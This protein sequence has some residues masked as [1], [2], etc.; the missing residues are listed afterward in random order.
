M[1]DIVREEEK[2]LWES[3]RDAGVGEPMRTALVL[4]ARENSI[5]TIAW[6]RSHAVYAKTRGEPLRFLVQRLKSLDPAPEFCPDC[7]GADGHRLDCPTSRRELAASWAPYTANE[8][9]N[10]DA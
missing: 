9:E 1:P 4:E 7:G 6:V 2:Q 3:L 10:G 8:E 5:I